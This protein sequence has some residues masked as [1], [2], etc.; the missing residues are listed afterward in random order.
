MTENRSVIEVA[1]AVPNGV[2]CVL[3]ALRM[4]GLT[5][6]APFEV[7]MAIPNKAWKPTIQYPPLRI[8]RFSDKDATT[9]CVHDLRRPVNRW[10]TRLNVDTIWGFQSQEFSRTTQDVRFW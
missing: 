4:H 8:V 5:T 2:V 3:T 6:Q 9:P 1:K 10:C 7:W